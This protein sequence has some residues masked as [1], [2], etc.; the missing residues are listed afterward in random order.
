MVKF[1]KISNDLIKTVNDFLKRKSCS[2]CQHRFNDESEI[3]WKWKQNFPRHVTLN[4]KCNSC[5]NFN[6]T[7]LS[8]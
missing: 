2:S 7:S 4:I 6:M 3:K 5:G 8:F 1:T